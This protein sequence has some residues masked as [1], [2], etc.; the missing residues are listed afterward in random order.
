MLGA[1][2]HPPRPEFPLLCFATSLLFVVVFGFGLRLGFW[3]GVV[4]FG[5]GVAPDTDFYIK[6]KLFFKKKPLVASSF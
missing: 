3:F 2:P 6:K 1:P 4:F 5:V